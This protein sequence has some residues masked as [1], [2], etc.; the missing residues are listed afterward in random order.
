MERSS[1]VGDIG[2]QGEDAGGV[3]EAM[4]TTGGSG[5]VDLDNDDSDVVITDDERGG[6]ACC[7]CGV[8]SGVLEKATK[9][10]RG[11]DEEENSERERKEI[12]EW[13]RKMNNGR[14][15]IFSFFVFFYLN[16]I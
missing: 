16:R 8:L 15:I 4:M 2:V 7:R 1:D 12:T 14:G 6:A 5:S 10:L 11:K 13:E 9:A 3:G